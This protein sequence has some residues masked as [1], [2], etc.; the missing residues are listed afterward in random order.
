MSYIFDRRHGEGPL[1]EFRVLLLGSA[2]VGKTSL[3]SKFFSHGDL[4]I[5]ANIT[6]IIIVVIIIMTIT[7]I[8]I[9]SILKCHL[10]IIFVIMRIIEQEVSL[11]LTSVLMRRRRE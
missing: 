11:V 8:I 5:I 9:T 3:F 6:T 2:N 1:E 4:K 7:L 10:I